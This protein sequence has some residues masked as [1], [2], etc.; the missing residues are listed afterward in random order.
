MNSVLPDS[1]KVIIEESGK[2]FKV[3]EASGNF[4]I[5]LDQELEASNIFRKFLCLLVILK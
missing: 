2:E 4:K 1:S 3:F 5:H